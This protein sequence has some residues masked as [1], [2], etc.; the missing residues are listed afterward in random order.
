MFHFVLNG[1]HGILTRNT[2]RSLV[3]SIQS[4]VTEY[5]ISLG[6]SMNTVASRTLYMSSWTFVYMYRCMHAHTCTYGC[7]QT[8][9]FMC[10]MCTVCI[11]VCV[12]VYACMCIYVCIHMCTH[13]PL[14]AI[15]PGDLFYLINPYMDSN[16]GAW[17]RTFLC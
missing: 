6:A 13:T 1:S 3:L 4:R 15:L 5:T 17:R 2:E 10:I 12:F 16:F 8:C 9:M 14:Y 7:A 11:H